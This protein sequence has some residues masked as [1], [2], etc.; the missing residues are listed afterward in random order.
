[1]KTLHLSIIVIFISGLL[2][3]ISNPVFAPCLVGVT[4]C[5]PPPGVTVVASTDSQFYEKND[6]INIQGRIYLQNYT[7]LVTIQVINPNNT[8]IQSIDVPVTN[9]TFGTKIVANFDKTGLYHLVTCVQDWCDRSYFKFVSEPYTT[10]FNGKDFAIK[11]KSFA[12]LVGMEADVNSQAL[13]VHIANAT[14][15][16]LQFVI[17]LPRELID[18]KGYDGKDASFR[19]LV[20]MDQPDKYMQP[21]NFTEIASSYYSRTLAIH[22]PYEPVPNSAGVWDFK[23]MPADVNFGPSA[24]AEPPLKLFKLGMAVTDIKC[25]QDFQL[26]IKSEDNSPA[27]VKLQTAEKLVARGWG[28]KSLSDIYT[29]NADPN[30]LSQFQSEIIS[31]QKAI[32]IVQ[33]YIK[34]K[35]LTL[36]LN[37]NQNNVRI[38]TSLGYVQILPPNGYSYLLNVDPKTGL[39]LEETPFNGTDYRY[40]NPQWWIELEKSYLGIASNRTEDGNVVW[41]VVYTNCSSCISN[42]PSFFV[43]AI[44]GKVIRAYTGY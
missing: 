35:N 25:K 31:S 16:G 36:S 32:Q 42:N 13:R 15:Q 9:D 17:G 44:T 11:Y 19:V 26:V 24:S 30:I 41:D 33:D 1:M 7:K 28:Y 40:K 8:T 34:E 22:I 29:R 6:T 10:T 12:D 21:A 3:V 14:A 38:V 37:T 43:D 5:G 20:G 23:I 39:P 27:C 18:S 4:K 2:F